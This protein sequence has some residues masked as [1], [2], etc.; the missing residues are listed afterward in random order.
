MGSLCSSLETNV[1]ELE[2]PPVVGGE[3]G[4]VVGPGAPSRHRFASTRGRFQGELNWTTPSRYPRGTGG[5]LGVEMPHAGCQ[6]C[7]EQANNF[8]LTIKCV[9]A[10]PQTRP[11]GRRP[12]S[13]PF[14]YCQFSLIEVSRNQLSLVRTCFRL[15]VLFME[16]R[17]GQM[18]S[19]ALLTEA[20]WL[21]QGRHGF[22]TG[23]GAGGIDLPQVPLR[24]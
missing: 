17:N 20:G 24:L 7:C 9:S 21:V 6:K 13:R 10:F 14:P 23:F 18:A 2:P 16:V 8:P 15:S 19:P 11:P 3:V 5:F 22:G 4:T 1:G 12:R